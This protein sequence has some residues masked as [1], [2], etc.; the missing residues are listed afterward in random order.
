MEMFKTTSEFIELNNEEIEK[1]KTT[2]LKKRIKNE[3][4]DLY[5]DYDNVLIDIF[6]N[7]IIVSA[8]ENIF[9]KD[10]VIIKRLSYKFILD[11]HYP[12]RP[13]EEIYVNNYLYSNLLKIKSD[14]EKQMVKKIKGQDCLCCYSINC[15]SNWS[16]AIRLYRIID[17]IKAIIK[18]KRDIINLLLSE[19]IKNKHN[20]PYANIEAYLI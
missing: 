3:C 4:N 2:R 12:F 19:K 5:K 15:A 9:D 13:P 17:E 20:I 16:P 1:I 7:K 10:N 14:Y 6:N 11:N 8:M 18:F